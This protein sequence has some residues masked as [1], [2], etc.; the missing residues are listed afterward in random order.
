MRIFLTGGFRN[1]CKLVSSE[2]KKE[3]SSGY[4]GCFSLAATCSSL[5]AEMFWRR[6]EGCSRKIY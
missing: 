5:S 4:V 1:S 3:R 2:V 6:L